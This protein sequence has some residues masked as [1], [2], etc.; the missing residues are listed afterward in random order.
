[1]GQD[2]VRPRHQKYQERRQNYEDDISAEEEIQSKGSW[3][4]QENEHDKRT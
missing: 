1:M 4:P 3:I 2:F